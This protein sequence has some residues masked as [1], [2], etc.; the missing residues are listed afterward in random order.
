MKPNQV[1]SLGQGCATFSVM[2]AALKAH[3]LITAAKISAIRVF[4]KYMCGDVQK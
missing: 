4:K 1:D 3:T 2:S